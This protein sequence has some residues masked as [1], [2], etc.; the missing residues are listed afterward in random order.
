MI[1]ASV[2]ILYLL[3]PSSLNGCKTDAIIMLHYIYISS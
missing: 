1:V 3:L 2:N